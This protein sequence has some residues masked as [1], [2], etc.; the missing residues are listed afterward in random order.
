M[1]INGS[2]I[3]F[4]ES[5]EVAC[6]DGLRS[7]SFLL[8]FEFFCSLMMFSS[9]ISFNNLFA[10]LSSC[11]YFSLLKLRN[12][13]NRLFS[14]EIDLW[15]LLSTSASAVGYDDMTCGCVTFKLFVT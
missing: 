4:C 3:S 12:L 8:E 9:S 5:Y 13:F 2:R 15:C 1:W 7:F 11:D 6:G 14:A 10:F